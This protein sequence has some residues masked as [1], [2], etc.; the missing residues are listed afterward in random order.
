MAVAQRRNDIHNW[1]TRSQPALDAL[2]RRLE[3]DLKEQLKAEFADAPIL[4]NARVKDRSKL[5]DKAL[6]AR[7]SGDTEQFKYGDPITEIHDVVAVRVTTPMTQ[8]LE[9]VQVL[10]DHNWTVIDGLA[11][12]GSDGSTDQTRPGYQSI[13]GELDVSTFDAPVKVVEIQLRTIL[14]HAWAELSHDLLY[15]PDEVP[16]PALQR[17]L[18]ALAGL[19]ELADQEF[20][21]VRAARLGTQGLHGKPVDANELRTFAESLFAGVNKAS[22]R[23]RTADTWYETLAK[24]IR[25]KDISDMGMLADTIGDHLIS[26]AKQLSP[27]PRVDVAWCN[28]A[29]LLD[30][31]LRRSRPSLFGGSDDEEMYDYQWFVEHA[32]VGESIAHKLEIEG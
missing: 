9:R 13:H 7:T 32:M 6:K 10:V 20:R 22:E 12:H 31:W 5:I 27:D 15:K 18:H 30:V 17:R 28:P 2:C 3:H 26:S 16:A 11:S 4:V 29:F 25:G 14:Q 8:E 21:E 19:L 24:R 1:Y 23:S